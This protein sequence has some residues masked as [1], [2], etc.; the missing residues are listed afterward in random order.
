[1]ADDG[2]QARQ[3]SDASWVARDLARKLGCE[4]ADPGL[5]HDGRRGRDNA[6]DAVLL[7][8]GTLERLPDPGDALRR[9]RELLTEAPAAVISIPDRGLMQEEVSNGGPGAA[10][11]SR[12]TASEL[13][14]LLESH[15]LRIAWLG[16]GRSPFGLLHRSTLVAV[17][18][19]TRG[20]EV[21]ELLA[22]GA[23][24]LAFDP[25]APRPGDSQVEGRARVCIASYELV[26]PTRTGGIGT[27]Y[28]SLA[29][30]LVEAG[31]EVTVLYTGW[32]DS[33]DE[34]PFSHW[35]D[36]YAR[37][38]IRLFELRP[39]ELPSVHCGH[40]NARR[41]YLAYLWLRDRD[42]EDPF[43]VIHFPDTL[44]HGYYSVLARSQ[45]WAFATTTIAI[46][47]HSPSAW[48]LE[49]NR[50]QFLTGYEF[51]DD[52]L[53]RRCVE[54]A[55]V[56]ISPSAYMLDWVRNHGWE[57]PARAH[58][59]QYV[60]SRSV[61]GAEPTESPSRDGDGSRGGAID[62]LV[63]FGRLEV[64]KGLPL[65]CDALDILAEEEA[66]PQISVAFLGKQAVVLG[67]RADDFLAERARRWP[68]KWR[69]LDGLAQP[70]AIAY[71]KEGGQRRLAVM[72]SLADNTP[73]T[74]MEAIALR[75]PFI[76]SRAGGTG[77]LINPF[78]LERCTFNAAGGAAT[79]ARS[80]AR[81]LRNAVEATE[82]RP[83]RPAVDASRN[84]AAHVS[85]HGALGGKRPP[86]GRDDALVSGRGSAPLVTVCAVARD[87]E[88][89]RDTVAGLENQ[90]Y[91]QF[92]VVLVGDGFE[93]EAAPSPLERLAPI[94]D[95]RGWRLLRSR[96]EDPRGPRNLAVDAARGDYLLFLAEGAVV[97][98]EQLSA[99][100]RVAAKTGAEVVTCPSRFRSDRAEAFRVPEGGPPLGGLF[101]GCFGEGA[102]MIRRGSLDRAGGFDPTVEAAAQDHELLCRVALAGDEFSVIPE[103]LVRRSA[104]DASR[105]A[106][107]DPPTTDPAILRAYEERTPPGVRELPRIARANWELAMR[108]EKLLYTFME[109][110]SWRVTR[111]LRWLVRQ[112]KRLSGKPPGMEPRL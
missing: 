74:V 77:E 7:C 18:E 52:F 13:K 33:E 44:G 84:E 12:W 1:M 16:L 15:G 26:G 27:A 34:T 98:P 100:V 39:E 22:T 56:V 59:Q 88:R 3:D 70:E 75:I 95:E 94:V 91:P 72:P 43:H 54:Q 40:Y 29:E 4:V 83:A 53:E 5:A 42:R 92:E 25:E 109:S 31:H 11:G 78:D 36:H 50:A 24:S 8:D 47:V 37:R 81:A 85:W 64:R 51:A 69:I 103:P 58:V 87:E 110:R 82:F 93:E 30:S 20:S 35:V 2:A 49:T 41:S 46:G 102:Y 99:F 111:P 28:T 55:D 6:Q 97:E 65:F 105:A 112:A 101:Y 79:G 9:L 73:N 19:G 86:R 106:A 63:F 76:A 23:R 104:R 67:A 21:R 71:L 48:I 45:G 66:L 17:L 62:E 96:R 90:D 68:W 38:G 108:Q 32:R 57:L 107:I 89:L 10:A 14:E 80:L 61:R 60:R